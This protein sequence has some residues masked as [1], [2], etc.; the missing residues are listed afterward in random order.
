[1][2]R[3]DLSN[4]SAIAR[5]VH[6]FL[7][8]RPEV[9]AEKH[10]LFP[11]GAFVLQRGGV[12]VGYAIAHPWS[13]DEIPALDAFLVDL[14]PAADC[15]FLHDVALLPRARGNRSAA[16]LIELLKVVA[17]TGGLRQIAL[18][19]VYGTKTL[20]GRLGFQERTL[21][22]GNH[23]LSSYGDGACYMMLDFYAGEGASRSSSLTAPGEPI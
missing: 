18:A 2:T 20:W 12:V 1:M 4:V 5:E 6:P 3:G 11:Q 9:L 23:K 7:P 13:L 8:E 15:L 19:S 10:R 14:S 22:A 21:P 17:L 16:T